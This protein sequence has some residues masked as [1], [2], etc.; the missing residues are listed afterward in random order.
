MCSACRA[1]RYPLTSARFLFLVPLIR[2]MSGRATSAR[3]SNWLRSAAT[4]PPTTNAPTICARPSNRARTDWLQRRFRV[5]DS[6]MML[7]L[8]QA[9]CLVIREPYEPAAMAGSRCR[10]V[11]FER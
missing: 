5:Q 7:P 4:S 6:S 3:P 2:R 9:D 1:I 8:S 10:I 11:K